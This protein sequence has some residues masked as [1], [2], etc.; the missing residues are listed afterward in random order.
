MSSFHPIIVIG[1]GAAGILAAWKAAS[2]GA[3]V[4]LLERNRKLGI[5][6]LISGG[7]KCNITHAGPMEQVRAAFVQREAR[8]LKSA[9]YRFS[10]DDIVKMIEGRG[11][12]TYTRSNGRVFPVSGDADDVLNA[13]TAL[14]RGVNV[15]IRLNSRVRAI[16]A[17]SGTICGVSLHNT[18]K[19]ILSGHIVLATGGA[20]YP[21]TGTTGDGFVWA[22]RLGHTIVPIRPVLAPICV[23]PPLPH[24]W[25]GI[26]LRSGSLMVF[27]DG[28]K[29][30][31]WEDDILFSHE[32]ITGPAAL[33]VSRIA[34]GAIRTHHVEL[35]FDFFPGKDFQILD[36][37]LG[38]LVKVHRNR[39]IATVLESLLPNRIVPAMLSPTGVDPAKRGHGLTKEERRKIV[40]LLKE[41]RLG[42]VSNINI[43]RGEVTAGGVSLNEVDPKTMRSRKVSGLYVCGEVLDVA[44]PV[45]GYNLQAAFSTGYVAGESAAND[46]LGCSTTSS[47]KRSRTVDSLE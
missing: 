23:T 27:A 21:K 28:K 41:W 39:M 6:L 30:T 33:E 12:K 1:G 43:E 34:A 37:E 11:V 5:K 9:L 44:G 36:D 18:N 17:S 45:G 38:Q 25:Q 31:S 16:A 13:L 26:A 35:R 14:L 3:P 7:G 20:S 8:F 46:W 42:N 47:V 10:N 29:L 22:E 15:D 32:G 4:L 2:L 24:T 40:A 19:E